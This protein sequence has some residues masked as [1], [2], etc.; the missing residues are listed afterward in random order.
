MLGVDRPESRSSLDEPMLDVTDPAGASS[1]SSAIIAASDG[2]EKARGT[3]RPGLNRVLLIVLIV[4]SLISIGL[5]VGLGIVATKYVKNASGTGTGQQQQAT[6]PDS[7]LRMFALSDVHLNILYSDTASAF[8][9]PPCQNKSTGQKFANRAPFGRVGCDSPQ[10]LFEST[11][12]SMVEV[13]RATRADVI[14]VTG[15]KSGHHLYTSADGA[16]Q[17]G[18]VVLK[19]QAQFTQTLG[20]YFPGRRHILTMGNNDVPYHWQVPTMSWYESLWQYWA[21]LILCPDCAQGRFS[22]RVNEAE[23]NT[24]FLRGGYYKVQVSD[25]LVLLI[26]NSLY[27]SAYAWSQTV[28]FRD[29]IPVIANEQMQW[30][31]TSLKQA[32]SRGMKA[33]IVGH[34]PPG[35]D[36]YRP[37]LNRV[38][39]VQ[40]FWFDNYTQIFLQT[41]AET[42]QDTVACNIFAHLHKDDFHVHSYNSD[43]STRTATLL[44]SSISPVYENNPAYRMLYFHPQDWYLA[45]Y[46]QYWTDLVQA[47]T[48]QVS[49]LWQKQYTF[50]EAYPGVQRIDSARLQALWSQIMST[51]DSSVWLR[52]MQ[53]RQTNAAN[54]LNSYSRDHL[55]CIA[56]TA[57]LTAYASCRQ[58]HPYEPKS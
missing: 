31:E 54:T 47:N 53:H 7:W 9:Y 48:R 34:V 23:F 6:I 21:P 57:N 12:S 27:W 51:D 16:N 15:D 33:V 42:F 44:L 14:L 18:T 2:S 46:T 3:G 43:N 55:Y 38:G 24:T 29:E 36:P 5:A 17:H 39:Y 8:G 56:Y 40:Q 26:V 41:V 49:A 28:P 32:E 35:L 25:G 30:L 1:I 50:S 22:T 13:D 19:A 45:D 11:L 4:M 37:H 10:V 58:Q 20:R 52:F